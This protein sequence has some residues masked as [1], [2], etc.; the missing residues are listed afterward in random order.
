MDRTVVAIPPEQ[1][2]AYSAILSAI[3]DNADGMQ[4]GTVTGSTDRAES[5]R[6]ALKA[7]SV[8]NRDIVLVH[9]P[10][11]SF[12]QPGTIRT[13]VD[14]VRAGAPAV[15][16]VEPV[17]DT[18]KEVGPHGRVVG[19]YDR[20]RLR[21]AQAPQGFRAEVLRRADLADPLTQLG[22]QVH[23]VPGHPQGMRLA[24][25]FDLTVIEALHASRTS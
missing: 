16:P 15:V 11:R 22:A 12:T 8:D 2:P 13:V 5:L 21:S 23:T 25:E 18:V 24:T 20:D 19:T 17:T 9:D 7:S 1:V 10:A 6:L 4:I 14:T 3:P